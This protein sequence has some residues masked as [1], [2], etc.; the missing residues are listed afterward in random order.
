MDGVIIVANDDLKKIH[1]EALKRYDM[2]MDADRDNRDHGKSDLL[3]VSGEQWTEDERQIREKQGRPTLTINRLVQAVRQVTGSLRQNRTSAKVRPADGSSDGE[4]AKILMGIIRNIEARS[5]TKQPYL[6]AAVNAAKCGIGHWRILTGY[7][8]DDTFEQEIIVD[9]I[10]NPFAVLWDGLARAVTREDAGYCFVLDRVLKE[11]FPVQFPGKSITDFDAQESQTTDWSV[12]HDG[13]VLI[14]EYW[15][16]TPVI[17]TMALLEDGSVI[18][19]T[20]TSD[21]QVFDYDGNKIKVVETREIES[22]K[23]TM[24]KISG[25]EVLEAPID[26]ITGDIPIIPV[27][28]EETNIDGK[29]FRDSVVRHAK[30]S[31]RMFNY[32][33]SAETE[34][35]ALQPKAPYLVTHKHIAAHQDAWA[36]ANKSNLPY[37]PYD[38]DPEAPAPQRMPPPLA[39]S[40]LSQGRLVAGDDIKATTGIFDASLGNRSN[41]TS[42]VAINSR[43]LQGETANSFIADNLNASVQH[44]ARIMVDMIP[45][46]YDTARTIRILGEDGS[47]AFKDINKRVMGPDGEIIT[48]NDLTVGKYDVDVSAGPSFNTKR[49]EAAASMIEFARAF[50]NASGLITDMIVSNMDWP[51]ADE[52]AKRLRKALPPGTIEIDE[53]DPDADAKRQAQEAAAQK[54]AEQEEM[55]VTIAKQKHAAEISL[56][57]SEMGKNLATTDKLD[58]EADAKRMDTTEKEIG[59][60]SQLGAQIEEL[61]LLL[62]QTA[63]ANQG[64]AAQSAGPP[65]APPAPGQGVV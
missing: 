4:I 9:L 1:R 41:E 21:D 22:H 34:V 48:E 6:Q 43:K 28:G 13:T 40:A 15:V 60:A 36:N 63:I 61:K 42:G 44:S 31:Q 64:N 17:K 47:E 10:S 55:L 65:A 30:D 62:Q 12:G 5:K 46:I 20:D 32:W 38:V 49:E 51:G 3:F 27:V 53:D 39:S 19:I 23:V 24:Y 8:G 56:Q 37:L 54:Q 14:A 7:A 18:D 11:S 52:M 45:K 35:V 29:V 25:S 57:T 50:P 16:K 33:A 2:A 58:A 59:I 26:W